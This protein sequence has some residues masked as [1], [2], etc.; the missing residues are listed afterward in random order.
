MNT[1]L[2]GR[3]RE[4]QRAVERVYRKSSRKGLK[5]SCPTSVEPSSSISAIKKDQVKH[6]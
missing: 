1:N 6:L 2:Q 5:K 3:K 4:D